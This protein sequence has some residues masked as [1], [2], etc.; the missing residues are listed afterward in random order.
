MREMKQ[1]EFKSILFRL[2]TWKAE[3]HLTLEGQV[4]GLLPNL[5][6][7]LTE[8]NRA[9]SVEE[10]IDALCDMVVF[11]LN[12]L[13]H[14][15]LVNGSKIDDLDLDGRNIPHLV[16]DGSR[17][18]PDPLKLPRMILTALEQNSE[19]FYIN[20]V[21]VLLRQIDAKGYD[22][23]LCMCET[24]KEIESRLGRWDDCLHKFIKSEGYYTRE[25]V[26]QAYSFDTIKEY[27]DR[28][29]IFQSLDDTAPYVVVKWYK[30]Q[31]E[32]CRYK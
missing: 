31:Y 11:V 7:E 6:E 23:Y 10:E 25:E 20:L 16:L 13:P 17:P 26:K 29:E 5:L 21:E 8:L 30:A 9:Q 18:F 24:L 2:A 12:A 22:P 28:F 27:S 4:K 1:K 19:P 15:E 32:N 3:R 14:T